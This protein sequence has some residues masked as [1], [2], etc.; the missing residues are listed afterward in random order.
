M[1]EPSTYKNK[2]PQYS[3]TARNELPSDSTR[4]PGPGA[5]RPEQVSD[6]I[7]RSH[8]K[9]ICLG[10]CYEENF[11]KVF[12]WYQALRILWSSYR[13]RAKRMNRKNCFIII[14]YI[15]IKIK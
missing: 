12:I 1:T 6:T 9:A 7:L 3:M 14:S 10:L 8:F 11:T 15:F 2:Q 5:Y 13:R 4:K